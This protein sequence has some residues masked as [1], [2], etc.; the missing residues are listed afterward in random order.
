[1]GTVSGAL[2]KWASFFFSVEQRNNQDASIY[3]VQTA[4]LDSS[5]GVYYV[6]T[7]NGNTG[8][9]TAQ[10]GSLFAPSTHTE[11]SPRI[12]LQ[13]GQKNTLTVRYQF[14]RNAAS[15]SIGSTSLPTLSSSSD[16]IDN[17]V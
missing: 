16:S 11:I 2:S 1:N 15:G 17:S 8:N 6:P 9:I 3:T 13:L 5:S 14:A 12:D 4:D 7:I 10:T